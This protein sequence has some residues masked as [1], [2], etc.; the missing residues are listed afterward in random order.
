MAAQSGGSTTIDRGGAVLFI[1]LVVISYLSAF[2]LSV[3]LSMPEMITLGVVCLAYLFMGTLGLDWCERRRSIWFVAA[4]FVIQAILLS[5]MTL[6]SPNAGYLSMMPLVS[7]AVVMFP[8]YWPLVIV[9]LV[10]VVMLCFSANVGDVVQAQ[11]QELERASAGHSWSL[12]GL[13]S[14]QYG[15]AVTFVTLFTLAA[16]RERAARDELAQANRQLRE[17]AAQVEE[18]ATVKERNRLARE[19]HDGLG[20]YLT[21]INVQ[22]EAARAVMESDPAQSLDALRKA[23]ALAQDGLADARRS[24]AALRA[25]PVEERPL[26]EAIAML[27]EENRAAGIEVAFT[28][29][30]GCRPLSPQTGLTL[31]RAAQEGLTNVR[32]HARVSEAEVVLEYRDG[33]T[34]RLLVR[35]DG[36]GSAD[37]DGGFGLLG[38][39]ERTQILGGRV[40]IR[41]A[42]GQGFTLEVEVPG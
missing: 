7:Q 37:V 23:Q 38:V 4:Y 30:G 35:D 9:L 11:L 6:M 22:I 33:G 31:Y 17:Y 2:V 41:T 24:V 12:V 18:L 29:V 14:A 21:V 26:P 13:L 8:R 10:G 39:R 16:V 27:V 1:V 36:T 32:R 34:V 20:H 15:L 28:L 42:P 40:D 25:S 3:P 19:I 5:L